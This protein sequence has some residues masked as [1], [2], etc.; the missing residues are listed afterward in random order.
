[1]TRRDRARVRG[2]SRTRPKGARDVVSVTKRHSGI[3]LSSLSTQ[4]AEDVRHDV[5]AAHAD[6]RR[7]QAKRASA[8]ARGA[9]ALHGVAPGWDDDRVPAVGADDNGGRRSTRDISDDDLTNERA[10][11]NAGRSSDRQ[12]ITRKRSGRRARMLMSEPACNEPDAEGQDYREQREHR[13]LG[14]RWC[15]LPG[16]TPRTLPD[17]TAGRRPRVPATRQP[18][19]AECRFRPKALLKGFR[20]VAGWPRRRVP[21]A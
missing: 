15:L 8:V 20:A 7:P 6:R 2:H 1:M 16:I 21:G 5:A 3:P 10:W 13:P 18:R 14:P 12:E 17:V 11:H 19:G 4:M 9:P